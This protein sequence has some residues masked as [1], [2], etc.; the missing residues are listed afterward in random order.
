MAHPILIPDGVPY[1]E[2]IVQ[3]RE[4]FDAEMAARD[5]ERGF[6]TKPL[7]NRVVYEIPDFKVMMSPP[8]PGSENE[9]TVGNVMYPY[10][11][12]LEGPDDTTLLF[13]S[14]FECGNLKKVVQVYQYEYDLTLRLDTNTRGHTQWYY[15]TVTNIQKDVKYK[16]NIVNFLKP[17]SL[18]NNGMKPVLYSEMLAK[19]KG[20]GWH[21]VGEDIAYYPTQT[22]KKMPASYTLTF[23]VKFPYG[24]GDTCCLAYHFPYSYSDLQNYLHE[25]E[26]DPQRK[27][28]VRRRTLCQTHAGNAV[29]LLTVTTFTGTAEQMKRR[30]GIVLSARVHPGETNASYMMKGLIDFLTG[31]SLE[32][33]ILRDNFVFKIVP[34]LNPDGVIVGNHRTNLHGLDLNRQW[35]APTRRQSPPI[36]YTKQ[37]I[38]K[39]S[40]DRPVIFYCDLHGHSR[41]K[42]IFIFGCENKDNPRLV[43]QEK[44]FPR[45]LSHRAPA[46]SYDDCDFRVQKSKE[47]AARVVIWRE[48]GLVNSFTMEASF[49]GCNTGKYKDIHFTPA[50]LEE[51]GATFGET[52]LDY[53]DN[54]Q[55]EI[56]S[57]FRELAGLHFAEIE[58]AM[59]ASDCSSLQNMMSPRLGSSSASSMGYHS[60]SPYSSSY[61]TSSSSLSSASSTSAASFTASSAASSAIQPF[62]AFASYCSLSGSS[63]TSNSSS[64][65]HISPTPSPFHSKHLLHSKSGDGGSGGGSGSRGASP[66]TRK[67]D[68][69]AR[70]D[71]DDGTEDDSATGTEDDVPDAKGVRRSGKKKKKKA[72]TM[73]EQRKS[74][75]ASQQSS[76][77]S[78]IGGVASRDIKERKSSNS[79]SRISSAASVSSA[80]SNP[81]GMKLGST[82]SLSNGLILTI[83]GQSHPTTAASSAPLQTAHPLSSLQ[84]SSPQSTSATLPTAG[85]TSSASTA[86]SSSLT[87]HSILP[88]SSLPAAPKRLSLFAPIRSTLRPQMR[89]ASSAPSFASSSSSSSSSS[90]SSTSSISSTSSLTSS[91]SYHPTMS[92]PPSPV[93]PQ[94]GSSDASDAGQ[95]SETSS[96]THRLSVPSSLPLSRTPSP[97]IA[98]SSQTRPSTSSSIGVAASART[99]LSP[100][101]IVTPTTPTPAQFPS[102]T[103]T[104]ATPSPYSSDSSDTPNISSDEQMT[105]QSE[106]SQTAQ[107]QAVSSVTAPPASAVSPAVVANDSSFVVGAS[108]PASAVHRTSSDASVKD[109]PSHLTKAK[110]RSKKNIKTVKSKDKKEIDGKEEKSD[111]KK[112]IRATASKSKKST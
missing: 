82:P 32:A 19:E 53:V 14:R 63:S 91:S 50:I 108:A 17:Y 64:S 59:A 95:D 46:F 10:I 73:Q 57:T 58:A 104:S 39:F 102:S 92:L 33:R 99:S 83:S 60:S 67:T 8:P 9:G 71:S 76:S 78:S 51:M 37:M 26:H 74:G 75:G 55:S 18:Y 68:M 86:S 70:P 25:L 101:D 88:T 1:V 105:G 28:V 72:K 79:A 81:A 66:M 7:I 49:A 97:A 5:L 24:A 52:L 27:E 38:K 112:P 40:E 100:A 20:Y 65:P 69:K 43:L 21:R 103:L 23:S 85:S 22:K 89:S 110:E 36:F 111:K 13:E 34:M 41:K 106:G 42:N 48:M 4:G 15:F 54:D 93:P 61:S 6:S 29:D 12:Q 62:S 56:Y 98:F 90:T 107:Q 44:V 96:T 109:K 94:S 80:S 16:F 47:G 11:Y 35:Q 84:S 77:G 45:M 31:P 3:M 2:P 30:R 87:T